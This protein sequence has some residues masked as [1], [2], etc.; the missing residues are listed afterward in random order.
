M[1]FKVRVLDFLAIYVKEMRKPENAHKEFDTHKL[2][3]GLLKSLQV[4]HA[5]KNT[6]LFDRIKTVLTLIAR[7]NNSNQAAGS[8]EAQN[9]DSKLLITEVMALVLKPTK[10]AKMHMAYVDCFISLTKHF[11]ESN[12]P[13]MV[14]FVSFT[15]KELLKKFLGGRGASAHSLNQQFFTRIFEECNYK[16]GSSLMKPL[17]R[18]LLPNVSGSSATEDKLVDSELSVGGGDDKA[19]KL[20]ARSNHQRLLA[21][22]IFN[23]LV[24]SSQ[25]NAQLMLALSN[26]IDLISGVLVTLLKTSDSWQ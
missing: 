14:K 21:I 6:I 10:D 15:Y 25:K 16:L 2:I 7:G 17:L 20:Q 12:D 9:K 1:E 3:K 11:S 26:S 5:D 18:Y 24:K 23:S 19:N 22:E 13:K 8:E 4:A